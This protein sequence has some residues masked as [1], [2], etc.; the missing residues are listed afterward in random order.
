[1]SKYK[2]KFERF[3]TLTDTHIYPTLQLTPIVARQ[4]DYMWIEKVMG[5]WVTNT[6]TE[7]P[8]FEFLRVDTIKE[9]DRCTLC[10]PFMLGQLTAQDVDSPRERYGIVP[11]KVCTNCHEEILASPANFCPNCGA[12]NMDA[13]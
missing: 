1:M 8:E 2:P 4:G 13:R 6:D 3:R 5:R 10:D 12:K 7:E 9:H 11:Y